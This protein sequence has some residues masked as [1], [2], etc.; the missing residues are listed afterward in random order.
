VPANN[1]SGKPSPSSILRKQAIAAG[2]KVTD[3]PI[4][5]TIYN[6]PKTGERRTSPPL[7]S[8]W[9]TVETPAGSR[10]VGADG[11][12]SASMPTTPSIATA[13]A[14]ADS[15]AAGKPT[16][17]VKPRPVVSARGLLGTNETPAASGGAQMLTTPFGVI[18]GTPVKK[19]KLLGS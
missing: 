5:G 9:K 17:S 6:N 8:G 2:W 14:G 15:D 10:Y 4:A 16:G 3:H 18:N 7:P 11:T 19:K 1:P 13:A 12:T